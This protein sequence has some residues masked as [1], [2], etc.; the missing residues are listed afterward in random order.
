M[1]TEHDLIWSRTDILELNA[2]APDLRFFRGIEVSTS[3]G[4]VVVIGLDTCDGI[5]RGMS[6]QALHA[7]TRS[8][9]AVLILVHPQ[10]IGP[11]ARVAPLVGYV[12]AIEVASSVTRGNDEEQ[13]IRL[14]R[15]Y[16]V[17]PVGGSDAHCEDTLGS[18][19]TVFPYLPDDEKRLAHMIRNHTGR[20]V[21]RGK[22]QEEEAVC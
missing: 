4:H 17:A 2:V 18:T 20:P 16:G 10:T 14:C 12:D 13:A 1:I 9:G 11:M 5:F 3:S 21:R 7:F 15:E 8:S 22:N 6:I 19:Y